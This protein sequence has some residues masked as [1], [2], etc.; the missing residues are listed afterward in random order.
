MFQRQVD[1][2]RIITENNSYSLVILMLFL[3]GQIR[4]TENIQIP[5]LYLD[6]SIL[7][8]T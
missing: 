3:I 2:T 6:V 8:Q 4:F 1:L 5:I 7:N